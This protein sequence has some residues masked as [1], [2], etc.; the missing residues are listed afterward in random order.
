MTA[1]RSHRSSSLP[2]IARG[3]ALAVAL[4][5][6]LAPFAVMLLTAVKP[7]GEV[8]T[9]PLLP[10]HWAFGNLFSAWGSALPVYFRNSAILAVGA[11]LLNLALALPAA[12]ALARMRVPGAKL[13]RHALLA[14]Q[15]FSPIVVVVSLH[16][17]A[18]MAGLTDKI[19]ALILVNAA[20]SMAFAVWLL[21]AY[22]A[23]VPEDMEEAARI[24]GCSRLSAAWRVVLPVA[25]PGVVTTVVFVF[26]AAWNEFVVALTLISSDANRPLTVGLYGFASAYAPQWNLLMAASLWA[27]LPVVLLFAAIEG[28][29]AE[30]LTA[31]AVK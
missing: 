31:G 17:L 7:E 16:H 30:G 6:M 2:G 11:T 28:S 22:L 21:T 3:L 14:T 27:I 25:R 24:D 15:M 23:A 20:Y 12:Y 9:R 18:A 26:I 8:A 10:D 29:L 5:F 13:W 19:A 1:K 4:L